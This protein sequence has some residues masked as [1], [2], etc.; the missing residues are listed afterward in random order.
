MNKEERQELIRHIIGTQAIGS[1][2]ELTRAVRKEGV[3][4]TQATICRDI[5]EMQMVKTPGKN[6]KYRYAIAPEE[7]GANAQGR[8]IRMLKDGIIAISHAYNQI[9]IRTI[10]GSAHVVAETLDNFEW[11]EVL[12][13]IAGDNTILVIAR[14][15]EAVNVL[16]KRIETM[17]GIT[18]EF[19]DADE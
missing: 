8:F 15:N 19:P 3:S 13:T 11:K 1:Q 17:T 18:E 5:K 10:S 4:V 7:E 2:I 16:L 6:G 14:S 12:G 9:V